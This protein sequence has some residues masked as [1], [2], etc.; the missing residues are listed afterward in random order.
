[1]DLSLGFP[2]D[3]K[4][5]KSKFLHNLRFCNSSVNKS[6]SI[7]IP[8][9]FRAVQDA[10]DRVNDKR[11]EIERDEADLARV[12]VAIED[13]EIILKEAIKEGERL[14]KEMDDN[15]EAQR[16]NQEMQAFFVNMHRVV[17]KEETT[18]KEIENRA[19]CLQ[20]E[21]KIFAEYSRLSDER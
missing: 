10:I 3:T 20:A 18:A 1:M 12:E 16:K 5:E 14:Q 4:G 17:S 11:K 8:F 19:S 7:H 9:P 21:L 2:V 13:A 15:Q 6:N